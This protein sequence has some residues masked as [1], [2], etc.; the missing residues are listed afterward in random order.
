MDWKALQATYPKDSQISPRTQ[1]LLA[2]EAVLDGKQYDSLQYP[3][4]TEYSPSGEYISLMQRRPSVR[5]G[6]CRL[7]IDDAVSLLF[8]EGHWPGIKAG[9]Q[10][11][12]DALMALVKQ[13]GLNEVMLEAA[14]RGSIGSV[15]IRLRCLS[16]KPFFDVLTTAY[17]T[18]E[19]RSDDPDTLAKVT[20]RY[21]VKG[22][23]LTD[24][25]YA[26]GPV[27]AE[28]PFW[29]QRFWDDKTETW[30]LPV[31]VAATG[32]AAVPKVDVE[33]T[34]Q[35]AL[36][37]VPIVW[38]RNL[39]STMR[40]GPEGACAFEPAIDTVIEA[41]YLLSQGG[42]ALKY[43]ADPKL[44]ISAGPGADGPPMLGGSANALMIP[45][46]GDAKLLEINGQSAKAVL[47]HVQQ[48]RAIVLETMHG[49]RSN[50]DKL[51]AA[52]SGR[53]IELM[54]TGLIWMA[55]RLRI[56][57]GE[58]ALL[59]LLRMAC[60]ASTALEGGL[61][62]AGK[63]V[64]ALDP[65]GLE[66]RWAPWMPPMPADV[67]G[68]AQGLVTAVTGGVLSQE[69]AAA[70]MGDVLDVDDVSAEFARIQAEAEAKAQQ[71]KAV[72]EAAA[73]RA[74]ANLGKTATRQVT[75]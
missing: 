4:S 1:R 40:L 42:R 67:L 29:F 64:K 41:D 15:A 32:G 58:G 62:I 66:L 28:T 14:T 47:E 7:A 69:T 57:Y 70:R 27:D 16:N 71:Q 11:T 6:L 3:F 17:L 18:P 33:R 30:F 9:N 65:A 36:G 56:S 2:L 59:D 13:T 21:T 24:Q 63:A 44:V 74:A 54:M 19:W 22:R 23:D 55:D 60:A 38:V 75:A 50:A 49:N 26:V 51:S 53:S 31:P 35:H 72:A 48:L 39:P 45:P 52:T 61:I 73:V 43:A 20:E 12:T 10:V 34:V 37:F 68:I 8:S 46:D 5:T 25:G